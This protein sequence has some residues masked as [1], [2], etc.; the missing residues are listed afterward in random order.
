MPPQ[1]DRYTEQ[2]LELAQMIRNQ[3]ASAY[4]FEHDH[5]VHEI[6]LAAAGYINWK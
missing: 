1:S 3:G 2:F 6:T 5:L 4:T